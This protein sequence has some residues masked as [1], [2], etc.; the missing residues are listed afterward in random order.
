MGSD[1]LEFNDQGAKLKVWVGVDGSTAAM[2]G[3]AIFFG[4][5]LALLLYAKIK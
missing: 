3:L 5:A 1:I 4:I 2:L